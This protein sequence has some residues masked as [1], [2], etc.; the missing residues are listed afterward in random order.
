MIQWC[1]MRVMLHDGT[2]GDQEQDYYYGEP[3]RHVVTVPGTL[4][5]SFFNGTVDSTL[6]AEER[7]DQLSLEHV[8]ATD[9]MK[10]CMLVMEFGDP[11]HLAMLTVFSRGTDNSSKQ[12]KYVPLAFS[13]TTY[14]DM[15]NNTNSVYGPPIRAFGIHRR[16]MASRIVCA[17]YL[18]LFMLERKPDANTELGGRYGGMYFKYKDEVFKL[19]E[20]ADTRVLLNK[21]YVARERLRS[22]QS[23]NEAEKRLLFRQEWTWEA[24]LSLLRWHYLTQPYNPLPNMMY[25]QAVRR[26]SYRGEIALMP[27]YKDLISRRFLNIDLLSEMMRREM[28]QEVENAPLRMRTLDMDDAAMRRKAL[29]EL[30]SSRSAAGRRRAPRAREA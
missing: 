14:S 28:Q 1:K 20:Y 24:G 11:Q 29:Q 4:D 9:H 10:N 2:S 18:S 27:F 22:D 5:G 15:I 13:P 16:A 25:R 21:M 17:G 19:M 30:L 3:V 8:I 23:N 12:D 6:S 7:I 26:Q